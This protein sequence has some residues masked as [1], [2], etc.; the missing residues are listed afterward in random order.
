MR[1]QKPEIALATWPQGA[2]AAYF[3][4]RQYDH[5]GVK[6]C[7][8]LWLKLRAID[9]DSK[10]GFY[11]DS[12]TRDAVSSLGIWIWFN[13]SGQ[14]SIEPRLHDI[15][16]LTLRQADAHHS[17]LKWACARIE[18]LNLAAYGVNVESAHLAL[19]VALGDLGVKRAI[20][21]RPSH[22]TDTFITVDAALSR[23]VKHLHARWSR[24]KTEVTA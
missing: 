6:D 12:D 3:G 24:M 16:S 15:H 5:W 19:S 1:K 23:I 17:L 18:K 22:Q 20:E 10:S 8:S 4:D 7:D 11:L 2:D 21:Y 13:K 9:P 14:L